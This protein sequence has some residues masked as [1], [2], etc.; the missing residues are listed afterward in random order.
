MIQ[1]RKVSKFTKA[2]LIIHSLIIGL[3]DVLILL[4][5]L[6]FIGITMLISFIESL[7]YGLASG[8]NVILDSIETITMEP[9]EIIIVVLAVVYSVIHLIALIMTIKN[10]DAIVVLL[11]S[12]YLFM[13]SLIAL[14]V[15]YI[16][17]DP[18]IIVL[19]LLSIPFTT[20]ILIL[21][22]IGLIRT[23]K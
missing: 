18:T 10:K 2:T 15:S 23:S 11:E 4:A 20:V 19:S 17:I 5:T 6:L 21:A 16:V 9:S 22:V 13:I 3:I 12:I 1:N 14:I 8:M 7:A